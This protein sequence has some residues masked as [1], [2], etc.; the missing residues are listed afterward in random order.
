MSLL[1]MICYVLF[2]DLS[3]LF[4]I[5]VIIIYVTSHYIHSWL[6]W[7]NI[8]GLNKINNTKNQYCIEYWNLEWLNNENIV[9]LS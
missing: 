7:Y 8:F 5:Q 3:L 4:M 9:S 6:K 2:Y 1:C